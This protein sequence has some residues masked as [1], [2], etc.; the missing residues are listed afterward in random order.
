MCARQ[1]QARRACDGNPLAS[2]ALANNEVCF[3]PCCAFLFCIVL[4]LCW[5]LLCCAVTCLVILWG[6]LGHVTCMDSNSVGKQP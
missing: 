2:A 4:C 5:Q 6:V 1:R 3:S